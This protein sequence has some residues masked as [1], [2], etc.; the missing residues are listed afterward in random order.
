[1]NSK[2]ALAICFLVVATLFAEVCCAPAGIPGNPL[3]FKGP[4]CHLKEVS[5]PAA[6][7][8]QLKA[9]LPAAAAQSGANSDAIKKLTALVNGK[10]ENFIKGLTELA[11]NAEVQKII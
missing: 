8:A 2:M 4:L 10:H 5:D 7:Q 11:K 6:L 9:A 1:M 3:P